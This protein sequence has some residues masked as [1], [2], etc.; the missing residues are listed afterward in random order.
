MCGKRVKLSHFLSIDWLR[1][2]H[3]PY[4]SHYRGLNY[5]L[6]PLA[7]SLLQILAQHHLAA[8]QVV[9]IIEIH[10]QLIDLSLHIISCH[11]ISYPT[12]LSNFRNND[13]STVGKGT[14]NT[15][16]GGEIQDLQIALG[17]SNRQLERRVCAEL[18]AKDLAL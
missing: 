7:Q 3:H 14:T 8:Q 6:P 10:H 12:H 16:I 1:C 5:H 2:N 15:G 18:S 11:D 4:Q 13:S 9:S 17:T